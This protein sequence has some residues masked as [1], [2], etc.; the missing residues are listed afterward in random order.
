MTQAWNLSQLANKVN[1]SGQLDAATGLSGVA[2]I[3][4]GGTNNGSLPVTAGGVLYTDGSKAVN[5]GAG[6]AGQVLTS[7]GS[8]A[9]TWT[10]L[11]A[12]GALNNIQY[13]TASGTYTPTASTSFVVVEVIGGG[14]GISG[15]G[16][17]SSF[18][19]FCSATGG[20]SA[21]SSGA[22]P[23]TGAGG[24]INARGQA[25][26][27]ITYG[28]NSGFLTNYG[29][30]AGGMS[31]TG[32]AG[33][34]AS[35]SASIGNNFQTISSGAGGGYSRKK[36]TSSFSGTSITVGTAGTGAGSLAATDGI[37]IVYEYK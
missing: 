5:S 28:S 10:A 12:G 34:G 31:P 2:P 6:T 19:A 4:N 36:I 21:V 11:S 1:T 30:P 25:G 29:S 22:I 33:Q 37:V 18:G 23:G 17:T 15:S 9:P 24:D 13:F 8:G 32:M 7:G 35:N 14:G 3:A 27:A 26:T 20:A 16:G